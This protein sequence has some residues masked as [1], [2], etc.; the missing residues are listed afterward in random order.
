MAGIRAVAFDYGGTLVGFR[1]PVAA[2]RAAD[3]AMLAALGAAGLRPAAGPQPF[4]LRLDAA[5][6]GAVSAPRAVAEREVDIRAV[7]DTVL[8][9]LLGRP[10][11][12]A[13][14]EALL[15]LH[16][17]AWV[18]GVRV[19][20]G[21]P[22]MLAALRE[23]RLRVGL[24]SNTPY[25]PEL[26]RAQLARLG[27]IDHFDVLCFSSAVGWRKPHPAI[28]REL[29][30]GLAVPPAATLFVGDEA[31]AD[32]GGARDAGMGP[33]LARVVRR[34]Q[35]PERVAGAVIDD[36]P[37]LVRLAREGWPVPAGGG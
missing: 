29:A 16:Q 4:A 22:A 8:T 20:V 30:R 6:E 7:Y 11:P 36:W 33:V 32:L 2:L 31:R 25:P 28:F 34:A 23:M 10:V 21:V 1:V 15:R 12:P 26:M 5:V 9:A 27:L 17:T 14:R 3:A 35:D 37:A 24:C 18:A 13:T 19:A